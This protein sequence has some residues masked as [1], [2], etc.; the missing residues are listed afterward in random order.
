QQKNA[1]TKKVKELSERTG[2]NYFVVEFIEIDISAKK[3]NTKNRPDLK[4]IEDLIT[5]R[6][7]VAV[8]VDRSDRLS[9]DLEYNCRFANMMLEYGAEYYEVETGR[10]DFNDEAQYFSFV[11]RSF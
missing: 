9:R 4:R 7:A 3:E 6:V 8:F 1:I 5:T 11:Y 2:R 10:V